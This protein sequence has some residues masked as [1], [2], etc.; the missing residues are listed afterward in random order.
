M[1]VKNPLVWLTHHYLYLFDVSFHCTENVGK[2]KTIFRN[3]PILWLY[4]SGENIRY[5][6][7]C[8]NTLIL[9]VGAHGGCHGPHY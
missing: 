6:V 4:Q 9:C 3:L 8:H 5:C 7:I 2:Y 1:D